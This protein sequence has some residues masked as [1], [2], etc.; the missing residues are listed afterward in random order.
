MSSYAIHLPNG[1]VEVRHSR[2]EA[3]CSALGEAQRLGSVV[4]VSFYWPDGARV[5]VASH[6]RLSVVLGRMV[7]LDNRYPGLPSG[8]DDSG[9]WLAA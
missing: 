7:G 5:V 8:P 9:L 1:D 6:D 4:V 3:A 2:S